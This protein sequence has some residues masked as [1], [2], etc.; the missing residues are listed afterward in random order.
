MTVATVIDLATRDRFETPAYVGFDGFM[1]FMVDRVGQDWYVTHRLNLTRMGERPS[2]TPR[3][4][5]EL[6][7]EYRRDYGPIHATEGALS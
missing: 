1:R 3:R 6:Q 7:A 4:Y 2:I 5:A